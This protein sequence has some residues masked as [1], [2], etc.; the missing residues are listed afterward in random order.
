MKSAINIDQLRDYSS[1]FSTKNAVQWL[2]GDLSFIKIKIARH[3]KSWIGT[4]KSY[5]D[6]LKHTY[7]TLEKHYQNE[8]I[9][10][11]TFL[12]STLAADFLKTDVRSFNEFRVGDSVADL[13]MFNGKSIAFEIKTGMD[14]CKRLDTQIQSYKEIFNEVYL[15]I[16]ASKLSVYRHYKV[17]IIVFEP[18][19]K[20][21]RRERTSP[22]HTIN[23]NAIMNV[24]HTSEYKN[25]VTQHYHTLPKG[26]NSFNQFKLCS[27]LIKAIPNQK[28]NK[29]FISCM[30]ERNAITDDLLSFK[31]FKEFK[32]LGNALKM[33]KARY[34]DMIEKLKYSVNQN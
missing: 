18:D 19:K 21:F 31:H 15:I 12:N 29:Y 9:F 26:I 22:A 10:K 13:A 27:K 2:N 17:G 34:Q 20:K 24:L 8:Y 7:K 6:Y 14:S 16:P 33:T 5:F 1:L 28:L 11:N 25:I 30:K 32:Q 3:N 4:N 23:P